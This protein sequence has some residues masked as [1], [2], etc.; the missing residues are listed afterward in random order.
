MNEHLNKPIEVEQFYEM[1]WYYLAGKAGGGERCEGR[2]TSPNT[3]SSLFT[4]ENFQFID[5]KRG[6]SHLAGD[7]NLY[8][9]ILQSF[10]KEFQ[11]LSLN[12]EDPDSARVIHTL[13]GLSA[14]IGAQTLHQICSELENRP[15][16]ALLPQLHDQLQHVMDEIERN[17]ATESDSERAPEEEITD[18][19]LAEK[20]DVLKMALTRRRS[21]ECIPVIE[22]LKRYRVDQEQRERFDSLESLIQ[23]RDFKAAT[24]LLKGDNGEDSNNSGG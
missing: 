22:E 4:A 7:E 19:I 13:K 8:A 12:F 3:A 18:K 10:I 1:L 20:I 2:K 9:K 24:A 15:D 11:G 17:L 23:A 16:E 5:V 21:R 14:N 6:L